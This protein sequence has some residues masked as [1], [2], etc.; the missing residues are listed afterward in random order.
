M[1]LILHFPVILLYC[2]SLTVTQVKKS[3]ELPF[4]PDETSESE[5]GFV[6]PSFAYKSKANPD[7]HAHSLST[8]FPSSIFQY[9]SFLYLCVY[10]NCL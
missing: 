6:T 3:I 9:N 2:T 4:E 7:L 8:T 1:N 10:N 5:N